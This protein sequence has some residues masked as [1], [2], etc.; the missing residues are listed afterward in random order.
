MADIRAKNEAADRKSKEAAYLQ[1]AKSFTKDH[2]LSKAH[3]PLLSKD[4]MPD[5]RKF[6]KEQMVEYLG[7][8]EAT[9]IDFVMNYLKKENEKER[10][11]TGLLEE[12]KIVLE[13]DSEAF[14]F[15][16]FQQVIKVVANEGNLSA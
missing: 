5:I 14:V 3:F 16:V 10:V 1:E 9:L 8:E 6:V 12:M 11:T 7:E 2:V 15:D 13:E 4:H